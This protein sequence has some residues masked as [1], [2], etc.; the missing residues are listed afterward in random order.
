[1]RP[2]AEQIVERAAAMLRDADPEKPAI[3]LLGE[4]H[5]MPAH[6]LLHI[7]VMEKLRERG[8]PFTAALEL[9]HD[10]VF[11]KFAL[12]TGRLAERGLI[13]PLAAR[14]P[15]G[16]YALRTAAGWQPSVAELSH[17][18]LWDYMRQRQVATFFND[19]AWISLKL[20]LRDPETA[21][22]KEQGA[23]APVMS[24]FAVEGVRLRNRIMADKLLKPSGLVVQICGSAHIYG[25]RL[26]FRPYEDSLVAMLKAADC[27]VLAAP[28]IS[29]P[30]KG[31]LPE[32]DP[33]LIP[34]IEVSQATAGEREDLVLINLMKSSRMEWPLPGAA[35]KQAHKDYMTDMFSAWD[36][37]LPRAAPPGKITP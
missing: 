32:N 23:A 19:A 17:Q 12:H 29:H 15:A 11:K 10:S 34:D 27:A 8:I 20:D 31:L 4:T 21:R 25:N 3:L 36:R 13:A 37:E 16:Q 28:Y 5:S 2:Q 26:P 9:P 7:V 24:A 35:E 1:M 33:A 14:D 30:Y 22:F 18:V 6:M